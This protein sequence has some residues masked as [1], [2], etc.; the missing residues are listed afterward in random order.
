GNQIAYALQPYCRRGRTRPNLRSPGLQP[1]LPRE[2]AP[3]FP[4]GEILGATMVEIDVVLTADGE[5]IILHDL[6]VDRTTDRHGFVADLSLER[7]RSLDAGSWFHQH[8]ARTRI[9]NLV[10]VPDWARRD[11]VTTADEIQEEE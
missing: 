1:P 6:T 2:H 7:I 4:G 11:E 8:F 9:P 10:E 5:P 3:G